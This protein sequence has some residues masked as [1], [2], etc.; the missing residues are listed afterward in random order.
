MLNKEL[1]MAGITMKEPHILLTVGY[2]DGRRSDKYG[3]IRDYSDSSNN[4]GSVSKIPCWGDVSENISLKMLY[5]FRTNANSV[6]TWI[7]W[8]RRVPRSK[9]TRTDLEY[10]VGEEVPWEAQDA[11]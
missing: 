5:G 2:A 10:Y 9:H 11:E 8:T 4:I 1:L 3:Y 7:R 6:G